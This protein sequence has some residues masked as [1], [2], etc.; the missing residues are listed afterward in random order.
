MVTDFVL[1]YPQ[2]ECVRGYEVNKRVRP[3]AE[4]WFGEKCVFIEI[5]MGQQSYRQVRNRQRVYSDITNPLLYVTASER[6]LRGLIRES[7][8]V[9]S[10]AL[11]TTLGRV[12]QN[13][14]GEIWEDANGNKCSLTE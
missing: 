7:V 8:Q 11:F 6:R 5:D 13:P 10:I 12:L 2:Y 1:C 4:F 3:D 9:H 14:D